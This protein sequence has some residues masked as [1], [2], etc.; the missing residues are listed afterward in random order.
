M[1]APPDV[2]A[3]KRPTGLRILL[4]G[5]AG[6]S[7]VL[8]P[9][10]VERGET[11]VG[12]CTRGQKPLA[13]R[14]RARTGRIL[15][16][17]GLRRRET[18]QLPG[19]LEHLPSPLKI[20]RQH[21]VPVL[22]ASELHAPV[23]ARH[24]EAL[25]PDVLLVAGFHRLI[26]RSVFGLAR[27]AAINF[28]PSLLPRHRG[29]TPNRW[30]IRFGETETGIT[31]HL[32]SEEFDA[33]DIVAQRRALVGPDDTWGE[34]EH[35]I[36]EALPSFACEVLAMVCE[37]PLVSRPQDTVTASHEPSF[38]AEHQNIDWSLGEAEI[39]R[40]CHAIR[41]KSGG[42][43]EYRGRP[44][45]VWEI[46]SSPG[47]VTDAEPGSIVEIDAQG[48]PVVACGD[49]VA[50]VTHLLRFGR[51]Q[52]LPRAGRGLGFAKGGSFRPPGAAIDLDHAGGGL[53]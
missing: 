38:N 34:I 8:L 36:A 11:I 10:L 43:T 25:E 18:F 52:P 33:G 9:R 7:S 4:F 26:P 13:K 1:T 37:G 47:P 45:C 51:V 17:L 27:V 15:R 46:E 41:P 35:R 39:R 22:E 40:T 31:A 49:G 5:N 19:P 32:L 28:H 29:G 3:N 23:F 42:M 30:V 53:L 6:Y 44:V 12:L 50:T 21:R 48:R 24:V 14:L 2:D 16:G 20:A